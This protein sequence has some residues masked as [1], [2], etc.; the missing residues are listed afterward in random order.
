[1]IADGPDNPHGI[2]QRFRRQKREAKWYQSGGPG[3]EPGK[4]WLMPQR[5]SPQGRRQTPEAVVGFKFLCPFPQLPGKP[6]I[7]IC[8]D[9]VLSPPRPD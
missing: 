4:I 9:S 1:M 6:E 8:S 5:R 7:N 3:E 2:T